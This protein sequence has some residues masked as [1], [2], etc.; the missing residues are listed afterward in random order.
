MDADEVLARFTIPT[1]CPMRWESMSGDDRIRHCAACDKHVYNLTEMAPDEIV[2]VLS[3]LRERGGEV[4]GRAFQRAD[5]TLTASG[6]QPGRTAARGWQFRIRSFMALIAALAA[7]FGWVKW[8]TSQPLRVAGAIRLRPA[9]VASGPASP[10][11]GP[12]ATAGA[13]N[14]CAA[15]ES[16]PE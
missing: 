15:Q 14:E 7:M 13:G 9:G 5:G 4:C 10:S 16:A 11:C 3:P 8:V 1:P 6:F 2:S 12:G